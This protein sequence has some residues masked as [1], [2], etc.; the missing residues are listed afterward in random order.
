MVNGPPLQKGKMLV[1]RRGPDPVDPLLTTQDS[2]STDFRVT[3][4][5]FGKASEP[6][7][8]LIALALLVGSGVWL[9]QST[10]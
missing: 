4:S 9:Y 10:G 1:V 2:V 5:W 3:W 6:G 8:N 7:G